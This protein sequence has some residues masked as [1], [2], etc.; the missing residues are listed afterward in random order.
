MTV[1]ELTHNKPYQCMG[2]YTSDEWRDEYYEWTNEYYEWTNEYY[3][4]IND[5]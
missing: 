1:T 3:E 5:Y 4:W 2:T